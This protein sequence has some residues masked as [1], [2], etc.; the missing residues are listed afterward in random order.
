MWSVCGSWVGETGCN[1]TTWFKKM[2]SIS[3][4]YISW[5]V[6]GMWII[7]ITFERGGH[8]FSNT[9]AR[10]LALA[11]SRAA[12]SVESKMATMQ[13]KSFCVREFIKTES[14]LTLLHVCAIGERSSGGIWKFRTSSFKFYLD[15]S[16]T[17]CSSGNIDVRN[18]V[19]LIESPCIIRYYTTYKLHVSAITWPSSGCTKLTE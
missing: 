5:T 3:Y 2:D 9:T 17:V 14:Q 15:Y 4:V 13:H 8:K 11:H 1:K 19:H 6:H 12:A 16:H 18:W 7:H 10:A